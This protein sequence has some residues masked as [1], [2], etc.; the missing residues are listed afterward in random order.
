VL[1]GARGFDIAS[2]LWACG[3]AKR[4]ELLPEVER[5]LTYSDPATY[6][7]EIMIRESALTA[8]VELTLQSRFPES[9]TQRTS[10]R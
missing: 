1:A 2:A 10:S 6:P 7:G 8:A 9:M 4:P 5:F 3:T